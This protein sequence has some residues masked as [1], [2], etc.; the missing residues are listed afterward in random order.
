MKKTAFIAGSLFVLSVASVNA[1]TEPVP[2]KPTTDQWNNHNADKYKLQEMPAGITLE[3]KF[4]VIG[5]YSLA[6]KSGTPVEVSITLDETNKGIVWIEGL[7]QG[8]IKGL[9]RKAPGTYKIPVQKSGSEK[10][11]AEGLLIFDK[12]KNTLDICIGCTYNND[13]PASAF[14]T[15]EPVVEEAVKNN[16]KKTTAKAKVIPVKTWKY[17]GTKVGETTTAS[18]APMQ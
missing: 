2:A 13:D 9:L 17:S 7:P 15:A 3:K 1:Q 4:P 5:K 11:V 18:V 6:D 14:A 8:K 10:D 12:D 16:N